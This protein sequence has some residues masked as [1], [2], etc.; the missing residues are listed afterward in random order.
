MQFSPVSN[1]FLPLKSKHSP[2]H[3]ILSHS[4]YGPSL[5]MRDQVSYSYKTTGKFMVFRVVT[6]CSVLVGYQRFRGPSARIFRV[7]YILISVCREKTG[8]QKTLSRMV[9]RIPWI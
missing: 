9:A 8:R 1:H 6:P 4:V 7:K 2:Q 5:R 3:P